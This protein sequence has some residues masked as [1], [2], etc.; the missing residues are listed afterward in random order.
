MSVYILNYFKY[1]G[2]KQVRGT[3]LMD[4]R[5][6]GQM[7][8]KGK[9]R[10]R[11]VL[12]KCHGTGSGK[13]IYALTQR[14]TIFQLWCVKKQPTDAAAL[15]HPGAAPAVTGGTA[16]S[17][18]R[19]LCAL[20]VGWALLCPPPRPG[21]R[22]G[23][24]GS[25]EAANGAGVLRKPTAHPP[26]QWELKTPSSRPGCRSTRGT[27]ATGAEPAQSLMPARCS[28]GGAW[29]ESGASFPPAF[30]GTQ[31]PASLP[32]GVGL[33]GSCSA[34]LGRGSGPRS[35]EHTRGPTPSH[36]G[37]RV[38]ALPGP[39]AFLASSPLVGSPRRAYLSPKPSRTRKLLPAPGSSRPWCLGA[40]PSPCPFPPPPFLCL[41][42]PSPKG[43]LK[44]T[45]CLGPPGSLLPCGSADAHPQTRGPSG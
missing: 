9:G 40:Q 14:V 39:L 30:A 18:N 6:K 43:L 29:G 20:S 32:P 3:L 15:P 12:G 1:F 42:L 17:V 31:R 24:Q 25:D 11:F 13:H 28:S 22:S 5:Y 27:N 16:R 36:P 35:P 7:L 34:L 10:G 41:P 44:A 37:S 23:G 26:F 45:P 4:L 19:G 8:R 21:C 38:R 2:G 33:P